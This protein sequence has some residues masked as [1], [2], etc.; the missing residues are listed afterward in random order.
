MA[1]RKLSNAARQTAR[2]P[3][4]PAA[5][6][7]TEPAGTEMRVQLLILELYV[8]GRAPNSLRAIANLEALCRDTALGRSKVEIVDVFREPERALEASVLLTPTLLK[9]APG[10]TVMIVGNLGDTRTVLD[11]LGLIDT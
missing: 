8:S 6:A 1:A 2:P 7:H 9:R 5:H 4:T 10:E 3:R 11:A